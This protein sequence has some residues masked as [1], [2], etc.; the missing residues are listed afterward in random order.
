VIEIVRWTDELLELVGEALRPADALEVIAYTGKD[1]LESLRMMVRF[2]PEAKVG[3]V[4]DDVL[5]LFGLQVH[6]EREASPWMVGCVAIDD[7]SFAFNRLARKWVDGWQA[8]HDLLWNFVHAENREAKEWL[9]TLGFGVE[10]DSIP[11]GMDD[12]PFNYFE[13]RA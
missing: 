9:E 10:V 12:Q 11:Y 5:G 13:W 6:R 3:L 1:V 4:D 7:H 2:C 8:D